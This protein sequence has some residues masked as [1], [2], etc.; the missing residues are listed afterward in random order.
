MIH[1]YGT[2]YT[3]ESDTAV[4]ILNSG[5]KNIHYDKN[6]F[7]GASVNFYKCQTYSQNKI[8]TVFV[9]LSLDIYLLLDPSFAINTNDCVWTCAAQRLCMDV[10]IQKWTLFLVYEYTISR[11]THFLWSESAFV[12]FQF[13]ERFNVSSLFFT[14]KKD[15]LVLLNA[16]FSQKCPSASTTARKDSGHIISIFHE[17][18]N[19]LC[20]MQLKFF[21]AVMFC[22]EMFKNGF[23]IFLFMSNCDSSLN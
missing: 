7:R 12:V 21:I 14:V 3:I 5:H 15:A 19:Y 1:Q 17:S 4:Q 23:H 22:E 9:M 8:L 6:C 18:E 20:R 16:D 11:A 13:Y 10:R 2:D